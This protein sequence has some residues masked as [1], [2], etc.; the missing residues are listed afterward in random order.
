MY[1]LP[2]MLKECI[3]GL[4]IRT[5]GIYVDVTYGG[6]GHSAAILE[7]LG[8]GR[9]LAFDQ[10]QEALANQ[11][12]DD[13]LTLI[14]HNFRYLKQ[15]LKYY[16]A[17]PVD[18]ILADL[19]VSSHQFDSR[20]RGFSIRFGGELDLRMNQNQKF[21]AQNIV[22]EY[23]EEQL[24]DLLRNYGELPSSRAIAS[25]IVKHRG[26]G[27]IKYFEE[28]KQAIGHFAPRNQENKFFAQVMQAF[29]IEVNQELEALKEM[30]MQTTEV[31]KQGGRLAVISYHSLEDRLVKNFIKTGN[32]EGLEDKDFFGN[33]KRPFKSLHSKPLVPSPEEVEVNNR[34]RSAKLRIAEKL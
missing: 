12:D 27:K 18:G 29:R 24:A 6:G 11:T 7:Q 34:S 5:G 15:F 28:L 22:N 8:N 32:F 2:V 31:L 23:S 13:R 14:H 21:S 25:A 17:V 26:A 33:K 16:N 19:G 9:L 4:D 20:E 30:L 3:E 10:D 1:H